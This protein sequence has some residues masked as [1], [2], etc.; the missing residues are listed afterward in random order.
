MLQRAGI[1]CG[2]IS[3]RLNALTPHLVI[4]A[5]PKVYLPY[6]PVIAM[7]YEVVSPRL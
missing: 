4:Y 1:Y 2:H 7:D 6:V 5:K 3:S